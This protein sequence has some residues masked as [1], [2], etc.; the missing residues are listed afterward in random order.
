MPIAFFVTV[1][2]TLAKSQSGCITARFTVSLLA[3]LAVLRLKD[4]RENTAF[5]LSSSSAGNLSSCATPFFSWIFRCS[6]FNHTGSYTLLRSW[7][8][9]ISWHA[10]FLNIIHS[11]GISMSYIRYSTIGYSII[12][13]I[14]SKTHR[15]SGLHQLG[16]AQL[17][18]TLN[19][20]YKPTW[21]CAAKTRQADDHDYCTLRLA[22]ETSMLVSYH[23]SI[24]HS[25]FWYSI[26]SELWKQQV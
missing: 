13:C 21:E 10:A 22:N 25:Y 19:F 24:H 8:R 18:L 2:T 6:L 3:H 16:F 1:F 20:Q 5:I 15:S 9:W 11:A 7:K 14:Q 26:Q 12:E 23:N 17:F 4:F